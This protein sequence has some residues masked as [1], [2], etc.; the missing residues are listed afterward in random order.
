[1]VGDVQVDITA[2]PPRGGDVL[3]G[4]EQAATKALPPM[5][6]VDGEIGHVRGE[7]G[8]SVDEENRGRCEFAWKRTVGGPQGELGA[9]DQ[10][11]S[12]LGLDGED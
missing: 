12:V 5:L 9:R 6:L 1:M 11:A 2:P 8:L 10:I 4:S 3:A 7:R